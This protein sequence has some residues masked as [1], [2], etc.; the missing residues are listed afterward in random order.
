MIEYSKKMDRISIIVHD[1]REGGNV[2]I[3]IQDG[4]NS[5]CE[6]KA[7]TV[8]REELYDLRHLIDRAISYVEK[9]K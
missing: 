6:W 3:S 2:V 1:L 4:W 5:M 8:T 9:D 7:N